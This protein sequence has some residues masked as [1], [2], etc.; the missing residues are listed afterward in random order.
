M[1][2]C[3]A[4]VLVGAGWAALCRSGDGRDTLP[5]VEPPSPPTKQAPPDAPSAPT[6]A[7]D[8]LAAEARAVLE[9][10]C[11]RCHGRDG[12]REGGF[13]YVLDRAR[14][15]EHK[16]VVPGDPARSRLLR[17]VAEGDM[18]PDGE[19]PRP[20]GD[21]VALLKRWVEAGAP[22]VGGAATARERV[23]TADTRH[24]I[25][26]DLDGLAGIDRHFT[27][28]LTL[29]HLRAAGAGPSDLD[30]ARQGVSKLLNSLSW[31]R[32]VVPT[33]AID[34]AG[35]VLRIDLRDYGWD[36][37]SWDRLV[38]VYPYGQDG[39]NLAPLRAD[40]LAAT[41]SRP[42]L[43][44]DLLRL[45]ESDGELEARLGI[46]VAEDIRTG[47]AARAGFNGSGVSRNN[48]LIERHD[49]L[50]GA[51]WKSYDFASNVDRRNL[52]GHPLG[53]GAGLNSFRHDGGEI[54]FTLPNGLQ[55]YMLVD[56]RG[57][58][59]DKGP[60]AIV[61]DPRRPD[62]AVEN[63][64]SCLSC[65]ARGVIDKRD[66]VREHVAVG[67]G[68]FGRDERA[69]VLALYP[70][71]ER[72]LAGLERDARRFRAALEAAGVAA[73]GPE[74]VSALALLYE[75][76]LGRDR[77][78]AELGVSPEALLRGLD[79]APG[80]ARLLGPLRQPGGTVQR[81]AFVAAWPDMVRYWHPD[82]P[83]NGGGTWQ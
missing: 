77:A 64:L 48:R 29:A 7:A 26:A 83:N 76:E 62:R 17:R 20:T 33:T 4:L 73:D 60:T 68:A 71:R 16:K 45:P 56:G 69:A 10:Y 21:E 25:R 43:Y 55:G 31:T 6:S 47:R 59:I 37:R 15:I 2:A 36:E 13:G 63:G 39:D 58:R 9:K 28:Y 80:L 11:H 82:E 49:A 18:P 75:G 66:Q 41:A 35:A 8:E 44:H 30:L 51:Y 38:A 40:W 46:D 12:S 67:R 19:Q 54:I 61:S 78:A 27:R 57:R 53:P 22:D 79:A 32:R 14:L 24:A 52:F 3:G 65:H 72:F 42:P 34:P 23:P 81:E 74:P 5:A 50:H 1:A 70:P